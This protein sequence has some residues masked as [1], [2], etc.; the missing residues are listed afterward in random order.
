MFWTDTSGDRIYRSR[1][2]ASQRT[3]LISSGLSSAEGLAWDWVNQK[4]YWTDSADD[5]IEV[6]DPA[7]TYR[8][9]LF[10][11]G[12]NSPYSIVVD[13]GTGYAYSYLHC[14]YREMWVCI[15]LDNI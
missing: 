15:N 5:D 10:E 8:R 7:T 12:L 11:N 4:L 3:T 1:L 9:V 13:P 6:Y 14:K 2:D